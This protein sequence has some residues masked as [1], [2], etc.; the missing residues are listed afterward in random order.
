MCPRRR[1]TRS[2]TRAS[3]NPGAIGRGSGHNH[4]RRQLKT[5][6]NRVVSAFPHHPHKPQATCKS[7]PSDLPW[8]SGPCVELCAGLYRMLSFPHIARWFPIHSWL[9]QTQS[10]RITRARSMAPS[11]SGGAPTVAKAGGA[12]LSTAGQSLTGQRVCIHGVQTRTE[13]NGSH[14]AVPSPSTPSA[15]G[16]QSSSR[17]RESMPTR[18]VVA[19]PAC[20]AQRTPGLGLAK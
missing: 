14:A 19:G 18:V 17:G 7:T 13:L 10:L 11:A 2:G 15:A 1:C 5:P 20:T 3:P 16:T 9:L 12:S 8:R 6:C 4:R